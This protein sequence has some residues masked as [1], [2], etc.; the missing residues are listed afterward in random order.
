MH[1]KWRGPLP[2]RSSS[3]VLRIRHI[4]RQS[5]ANYGPKSL[6]VLD[7]G[8]LLFPGGGRKLEP[9][10][11]YIRVDERSQRRKT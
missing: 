9:L 8:I 3:G 2:S 4:I 7:F 1:A 10:A 5:L 6:D 11:C